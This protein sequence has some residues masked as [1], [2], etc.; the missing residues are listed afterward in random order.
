[1][2]GAGP[3]TKTDGVPGDCSA[4]GADAQ[5]VPGKKECPNCGESL[6][7][8]ARVCRF[9]GY[10]FERGWMPRLRRGHAVLVAVLGIFG[11]VVSIWATLF[12][13]GGGDPESRVRQCMATHGL[14]RAREVSRSGG[15]KVF[16]ACQ[17]PA[18]GYADDDGYSDI[19]VRSIDRSRF[20]NAGDTSEASGVSVADKVTMP[21]CGE[22][23]AVYTFGSQGDFSQ[24]ELLLKA[25]DVRTV[26]GEAWKNDSERGVF[27]GFYPSSDDIVVLH[28]S[29]EVI[30]SVRC[31]S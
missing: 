1:M 4:E 28:T 14:D 13:D 22:V 2:K 27:L 21:G 26:E 12:R 31:I 3:P 11:A 15:S 29:D 9:C 19:R 24:R 23:K 25:G 18:P 17:W 8:S 6:K 20:S 30:D 10:R 16:S 7:Q 5:T